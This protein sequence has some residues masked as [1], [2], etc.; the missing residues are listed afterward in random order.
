MS[1][2]V[3]RILNRHPSNGW[4]LET[5]HRQPRPPR[6]RYRPSRQIVP[7]RVW[8]SEPRRAPG[9]HQWMTL[10]RGRSS[11]ALENPAEARTLRAAD[12][13]GQVANVQPVALVNDC[14]IRHRPSI[15]V[16]AIA[17]S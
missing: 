15:Q 1:E 6:L 16:R 7:R 10:V 13:I 12:P 2:E 9:V 17:R 14:V 4:A 8:D 3:H 5:V 11:C